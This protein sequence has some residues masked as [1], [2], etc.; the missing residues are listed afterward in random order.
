MDKATS[1]YL[2]EHCH[3]QECGHQD[4][5]ADCREP[6]LIF[7]SG[8]ALLISQV[9]PVKEDLSG[10]PGKHPLTLGKL[11]AHLGFLFV[12]VFP[13]GETMGQEGPSWYGIVPASES[14]DT[15]KM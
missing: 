7:F 3:E 5:S 9:S 8:V 1:W 6:L 13:A 14:S 2:R 4:L 10:P 15:V 11:E 12:F